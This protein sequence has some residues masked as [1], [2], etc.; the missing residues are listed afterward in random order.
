VSAEPYARL[1]HAERDAMRDA[2]RT[3]LARAASAPARGSSSAS[4]EEAVRRWRVAA[5]AGWLAVAVPQAL[6]GLGLSMVE[7]CLVAEEHGRALAPGCVLQSLAAGWFLSLHR[8]APEFA[9]A[10][11]GVVSG[12]VRVVCALEPADPGGLTL[13]PCGS[14]FTVSGTAGYVP[15]AAGATHLLA[16]GRITAP[17]AEAP[18]VALIDLEALGGDAIASSSID[19]SRQF[20]RVT[21][22]RTRLPETYVVTERGA[23]DT[24]RSALVVLQSAE[25][26]GAATAV[27]E[28]TVAYVKQR[29]QFGRTIGSFQAIKHRCADMIIELEGARAA[30]DHAASAADDAPELLAEASS[31]A[32]AWVG[33]GLSWLASEAIQ[34][35]GGI[36]FTWEHPLHRYV[37]RLKA[38]ELTL[39]SPQWHRQALFRRLQAGRPAAESST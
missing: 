22:P 18:C 23:V 36:G 2:L 35:H 4:A 33:P 19:L 16:A 14:D 27:M 38:N 10:I 9:E 5:E 17:S 39:G 25:S 20:S 32:A 37:R 21:V 28:M 13:A 24:L 30:V 31:L 26:L 1:S 6:G 34:L 15:D 3:A 12:V 8:E 7:A 11:E 29:E